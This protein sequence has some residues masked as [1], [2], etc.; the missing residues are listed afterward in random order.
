MKRK[1]S[2]MLLLGLAAAHP[3]WADIGR[4]KHASG[5]AQVQRG[6]T[7]V[8]ASPGFQLE[9]GDTLV[10]GR[11]GRMALTFVDNT[12]FALGPN[13]RVSVNEYLFDRKT[14]R[15]RFVTQVNR[16][17]LAVVSG[18][19]AKSDRD[20]MKVRTPT[21]LLGVRGTRFIVAVP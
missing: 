5:T 10:T 4:V 16:G 7:K 3:A 14:Q 17:T 1:V 2:A 12:R 8:S 11:D 20:A 15:G 18:Q 19:I 6:A 13:S 21:S 9:K